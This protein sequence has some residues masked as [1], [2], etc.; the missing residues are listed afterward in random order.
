MRYL[1][2]LACLTFGLF[3]PSE[4]KAGFDCKRDGSQRELAKCAYEDLSKSDLELKEKLGNDKLFD[5]WRV[6]RDAICDHITKEQF[7]GGSIRPMMNAGCRRRLNWESQKFC[8]TGDPKC[9]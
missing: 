8:V 3:I 4:A 2:L 9:G 6:G 1:Y 5:K 7:N